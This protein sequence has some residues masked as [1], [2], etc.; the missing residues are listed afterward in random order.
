M[1]DPAVERRVD[2]GHLIFLAVIASLVIWYLQD[3][4]SVSTSA[5]NLLMVLPLA[6]FVLAFCA[7]IVPQ[8]F[9][10]DAG[11][12]K[13][14]AHVMKE[15]SAD[16]LR[17]ADRKKLKIILGMAASLGCYVFL[18]NIIGFD[19]S[20]VLFAGVA[21]F[22]CGE[23]RPLRLAIY[24]LLVGGLLVWGFRALLPFPMYTLII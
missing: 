13:S 17:S 18:L 3:A 5:A 24:S 14:K 12:R 8:C 9:K 6:I 15:L 11:P 20:T 4:I 7:I 16:E 1:K 10:K 21:M 2:W 23:R 22:I 19:V